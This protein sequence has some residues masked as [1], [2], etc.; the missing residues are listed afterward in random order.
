VTGQ[1]QFID[2]TQVYIKQREGEYH[3]S[4]RDSGWRT[5]ELLWRQIVEALHGCSVYFGDVRKS[6]TR[7]GEPASC[8]E[9]NCRSVARLQHI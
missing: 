4:G 7:D 8:W 5:S 9:A 6:G 3:G 2:Y 1:S